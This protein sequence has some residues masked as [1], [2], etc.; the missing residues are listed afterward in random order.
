M[1]TYSAVTGITGTYQ[2]PK[3]NHAM[4]LTAKRSCRTRKAIIGRWTRIGA[5]HVGERAEKQLMSGILAQ[6]PQA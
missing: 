2:I 6:T 4:R 3:Q 1:G 5:F